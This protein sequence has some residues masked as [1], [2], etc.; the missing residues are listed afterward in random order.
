VTAVTC[1]Q[2]SKG[3]APETDAKKL[4]GELSRA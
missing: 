2:Q 1:S 3:V 4:V